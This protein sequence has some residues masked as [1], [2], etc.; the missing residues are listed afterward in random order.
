VI[1][2]IITFI[3][4]FCLATAPLPLALSWCCRHL[5]HISNLPHILVSPS[6][7]DILL[8]WFLVRAHNKQRWVLLSGLLHATRGTLLLHQLVIRVKNQLV[9][10]RSRRKVRG[11]LR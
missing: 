10:G 1:T 5:A 2:I 9:W 3:F 7:V 6:Q 11:V 4:F 8:R